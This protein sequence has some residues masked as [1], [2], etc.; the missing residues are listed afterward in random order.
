M[1]CYV[2][3]F[4]N[5][6]DA[7]IC[8]NC[9]TRLITNAN[10]RFGTLDE[11]DKD[12]IIA[13]V[14]SK[15]ENNFSDLFEEMGGLKRKIGTLDQDIVVLRNGL[16]SLVEILSEKGL[17]QR[18]K[19][20][21]IWENRILSDI[22]NKE[23]RE[24]F[25]AYKESILMMFHGRNRDVC[26]QLV[27]DAE[28][29][30][31]E[32][33]LDEGL[34]MFEKALK[35]NPEN[36]RLAFYLGQTFYMRSDLKRAR[37][38]FQQTLESHPNDYDA[39]LFLGLVHN[40][41]GEIEEAV[42]HLNKALEISSEFYLPFFTLGT[43]FYFEGNLKLAEFFL[44]MALERE[45]LP[46]ILFF[47]AL[48]KKDINQP[49]KAEKLL[50]KTIETD[51][52]FEDAYYYLGMVYLELG[53]SRKAKEMFEEVMQLNPSRLELVRPF[54]FDDESLVYVRHNEEIMKLL[55]K[56]DKFAER[57]EHHRA[58]A[59]CR[60]LLS[61]ETGNPLVMVHLAMYLVDSEQV[62]EAALLAERIL[63]QDV[64]EGIGLAAYSIRHSALKA[65]GQME[66]AVGLAHEMMERYPS[67]YA[68]TLGYV[69]LAMD[70]CELKNLSDA[71]ACAKTGL[72]ISDRDLR[73]HALDALAWVNY[74]K[75]KLGK[76]YE[77]LQES[78]SLSP[79]NPLAL[80]HLG[81]VLL[82]MKRR[83]EAEQ[84]LKKLLELREEGSP[85]PKH[86]IM[87]IREHLSALKKHGN[88][89][90]KDPDPAE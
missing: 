29:L 17:I 23:E 14:F 70:L 28:S 38:F 62:E 66:E 74:R 83:K 1:Y 89:D 58:I 64:P 34:E 42:E 12:N 85:F 16:L 11:F 71:E 57:R 54:E 87:S 82:S 72:K 41:T 13:Q 47:M 50:L 88:S 44:S 30:I 56:C 20:S 51:P 52:G 21:H 40:D 5:S 81:I 37:K 48:V 75:R 69:N 4:Y 10:P 86:L 6:E 79:G 73:H 53:W 84:I 45:K 63:S 7:P 25:Q 65:A 31:E 43:I 80:Y 8:S 18:D 60:G 68:K 32:G 2:C 24:R 33:D 46:E 15:F 35:K 26:E 39:N 22:Q 55:E 78:L 36:Y 9:G 3:G 61:V 59:Y 76:A 67:D 27:L 77:L 49:R 19:F 90:K